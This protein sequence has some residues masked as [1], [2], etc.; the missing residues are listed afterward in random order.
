MNDARLSELRDEITTATFDLNQLRQDQVDLLPSLRASEAS[1]SAIAEA[2]GIS[3]A[4]F[5]K[6]G[7]DKI[8]AGSV[9][10]TGR[11]DELLETVREFEQL[12]GELAERI[13]AMRRERDALILEDLNGDTKPN[14]VQLSQTA[15]V[16]Q[17]WISRIKSGKVTR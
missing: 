5:Y 11:R 7:Y 14:W 6:N 4:A 16:S 13:T 8:G 12:R 15:G 17:E 9:G 2:F 1:V 10:E 3:R